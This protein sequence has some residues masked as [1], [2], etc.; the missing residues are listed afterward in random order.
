VGR[1]ADRRF[2]FL[3]LDVCLGSMFLLFTTDLGLQRGFLAF[4]VF[5][6][7][8][9]AF[10]GLLRRRR[11]T[12]PGPLVRQRFQPFGVQFGRFF[13]P[14]GF[15]QRE[16]FAILGKFGRFTFGLFAL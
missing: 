14:L 10:G 2:G 16:Q 11:F 4:D 12:L 8:P 15:E 7:G 3:L 5:L 13:T 6:S 1:F 9:D